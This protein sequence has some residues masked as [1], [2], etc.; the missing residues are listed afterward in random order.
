MKN[1]G[2][3]QSKSCGLGRVG[4]PPE[5]P[6]VTGKAVPFSC[7]DCAVAKHSTR[8]PL[9]PHRN[10]LSIPFGQ[11]RCF[12]PQNSPVLSLFCK[13]G[14]QRISP[15]SMAID[16]Y[17]WLLFP[18]RIHSRQATLYTAHSLYRNTGSSPVSYA[19]LGHGVR[20][21]AAQ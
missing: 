9:S 1:G 3:K 15:L 8:L 12:P 11:P 17:A 5:Q 13:C 10:P 14:F 20:A 7:S 16:E 21:A 4:F 18:H 2:N 6:P 19:V